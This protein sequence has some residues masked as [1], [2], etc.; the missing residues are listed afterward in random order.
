[1]VAAVL[2]GLGIAM[3]YPTLLAAIGDYRPRPVPSGR[4][5]W[6]G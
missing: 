3:V 6:D 1:V 2:P 5:C 4:G